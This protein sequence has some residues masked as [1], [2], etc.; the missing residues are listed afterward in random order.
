MLASDDFA[1]DIAV[2]ISAPGTL[3]GLR[4]AALA[5][6]F[7][8]AYVETESPLQEHLSVGWAFKT[9]NMELLSDATVK[10][11]SQQIDRSISVTY[12]PTAGQS[13]LV[14]KHFYNNSASPR[15]NVMPRDRGTG[16]TH[17]ADS[18]RTELDM[19]ANRVP[20]GHATGVAQAKFGNR[21]YSDLGGVDRHL[22][23]ELTQAQQVVSPDQPAP[24]PTL[25]SY[26]I[27]GVIVRDE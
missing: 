13:I 18:T 26:E 17:I 2:S 1:T 19:D 25:Y 14:L 11:G 7:P 15:Q 6:A 21:A 8:P 27:N 20:L 23:I 3:G 9:P 16:F 4:A 22:A 12:A 24:V 10:G 5:F